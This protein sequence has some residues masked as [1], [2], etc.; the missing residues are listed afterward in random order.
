MREGKTYE[1]KDNISRIWEK[2]TDDEY[3]DRVVHKMIRSTESNMKN[4]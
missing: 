1:E 3:S 4:A 2:D